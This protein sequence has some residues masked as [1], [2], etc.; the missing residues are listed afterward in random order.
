MDQNSQVGQK[1]PDTMK[2]IKCTDGQVSI[3]ECKVPAYDKS[4]E[5]LICVQSTGLNRADLLQ[6]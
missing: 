3:A 6:S 4:F 1:V 5:V 2:H